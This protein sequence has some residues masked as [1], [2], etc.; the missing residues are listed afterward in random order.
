MRC[1]AAIDRPTFLPPS[2]LSILSSKCTV[3]ILGVLASV[4]SE[5]LYSPNPPS[6]QSNHSPRVNGIAVAIITHPVS[7]SLD[8]PC[9]LSKLWLL[10]DSRVCVFGRVCSIPG[11]WV[12]V[13]RR[14]SC[15]LAIVGWSV[16][17]L[18]LWLSVPGSLVYACNKQKDKRTKGQNDRRGFSSFIMDI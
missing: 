8:R 5:S 9:Q 11:I 10:T 12:G 18:W 1:T 6:P 2:Y 17:A 14:L 15:V 4:T 3:P 16:F 13:D 7:F